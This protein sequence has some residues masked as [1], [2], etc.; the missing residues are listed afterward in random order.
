MSKMIGALLVFT[1]LLPGAFA[2]DYDMGKTIGPKCEIFEAKPNDFI[3]QNGRFFK[4]TSTMKDSARYPAYPS[5]PKAVFLGF[6]VYEAIASF[7]EDQ[8]ARFYLS[9]YNRG[10]AGPMETEKFNSLVDDFRNALVKYTGEKGEELKGR[11]ASGMTVNAV[12][13]IRDGF[14]YTMKWSI[15]GHSRRDKQPEYLQLEIE[16]F[17][18][19]NDPRRRALTAVDRSKIE[20][21]QELQENVKRDE[22]GNVWISG[23]PMVDQGMKGY[24][25][26]AVAERVLKYYGC[27]GVNQHTIAQLS[28]TD[29]LRGTSFA[30]MVESLRKAGVKFGITLKKRY[31]SDVDSIRDLEKIVQR[32]NSIAR[33]MKKKKV[34]I[35]SDDEFV[36]LDRTFAQM[37]LP[38]YR[39]YKLKYEQRDFR[40]FK[41]DIHERIGKGLPLVWCVVL[42][43][44]PDKSA[45][46]AAGG[47][48]RLIIG[49]N[50]KTDELIY[51]DTWGAAHE[52]KTMPYEDAWTIT[53]RTMFINPRTSSR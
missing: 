44:I 42:G 52:F 20:T 35:I 32:Y 26:A 40:D 27:A 1:V 45:P 46:Q 49:Y 12:V 2:A 21:K 41:R 19:K 6:R 5:S 31:V 38:V 8:L 53:T 16:K 37:E 28:G 18:P 29:A 34:R 14:A 7:K 43:L 22:K 33:R 9:V 47:H 39:A 48:M 23:I 15:S 25:A 10:D 36:Y 4:W 51:S 30:A 3:Q 11:L 17:D 13:W 50:D 24:C